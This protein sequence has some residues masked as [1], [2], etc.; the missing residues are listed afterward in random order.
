MFPDVDVPLVSTPG[1]GWRRD[2][3]FGCTEGSDVYFQRCTMNI[4]RKDAAYMSIEVQPQKL[5][6]VVQSTYIHTQSPLLTSSEILQ[7][8]HAARRNVL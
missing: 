6:R 3:V 7:L 1:D 5:L 8:P 2:G 4:H